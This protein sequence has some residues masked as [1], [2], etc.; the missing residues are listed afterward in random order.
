M[1]FYRRI[2][3]GVA[4]AFH[5]DAPGRLRWFQC[6]SGTDKIYSYTPADPYGRARTAV[7]EYDVTEA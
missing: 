4:T 7:V 6:A 2:F 3:A 5:S 1:C